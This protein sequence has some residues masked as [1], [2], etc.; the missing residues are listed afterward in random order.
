M[1][2]RARRSSSFPI[3]SGGRKYGYHG[4]RAQLASR[5]WWLNAP[6]LCRRSVRRR[7]L[8]RRLN[9]NRRSLEIRQCD[10]IAA[11]RCCC[12][13]L[14]SSVSRVSRRGRRL[15]SVALRNRASRQLVVL[16]DST[17]SAW[18]PRHFSSFC[19]LHRFWFLPGLE[20]VKGQNA[21]RE[22][23]GA[24]KRKHSKHSHSDACG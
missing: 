8:I 14:S 11:F 22:K 7:R 2:I 24:G 12:A 10:G 20:A 21:I 6:A 15:A 9:A 13:M 23:C 19:R 4:V 18:S 16:T 1:S 5:S 17:H 3:P